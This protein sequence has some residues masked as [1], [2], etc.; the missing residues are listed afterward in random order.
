MQRHAKS[1]LLNRGRGNRQR[2][3]GRGTE[4]LHG[5]STRTEGTGRGKPPLCREEEEFW[6][7]RNGGCRAR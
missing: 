7:L 3:E 6:T 5:K 4:S 1:G 2:T